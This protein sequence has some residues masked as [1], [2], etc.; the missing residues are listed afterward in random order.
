MAHDGGAPLK[1]TGKKTYDVIHAVD[2][3]V[4]FV[5][6]ICRWRKIKLVY[7]AERCFAQEV[8]Q[9]PS[10]LWKLFPRHFFKVEKKIL[11]QA[12]VIFSTCDTLTADLLALNKNLKIMQVEDIPAQPLFAARVG[13]K[14]LLFEQFSSPPS[15]VVVCS[16]VQNNQKEYIVILYLGLMTAS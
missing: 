6:Q 13:D 8:G 14:C 7:D 5:A 1:A 15:C 9:A 3:G 12:S 11:A 10:F 2:I 16:V 4:G